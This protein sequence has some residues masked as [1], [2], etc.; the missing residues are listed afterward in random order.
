MEIKITKKEI[1]ENVS[2]EMNTYKKYLVYVNAYNTNRTYRFKT[3]FIYTI[4]HNE[5]FEYADKD[6]LTLK[7]QKEITNEILYSILDTFNTEKDT[8]NFED[9]KIAVKNLREFC[10]E[11][12]REYNKS[13]TRYAY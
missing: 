3:K 8:S 6:F 10:N 13:I 4:E 5:L 7:E 9:F 12:I 1:L 11:T 2:N